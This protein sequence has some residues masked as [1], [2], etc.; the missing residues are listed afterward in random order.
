MDCQHVKLAYIFSPCIIF[1]RIR[2]HLGIRLSLL[3]YA[4]DIDDNLP[5]NFNWIQHICYY[6]FLYVHL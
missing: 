2:F 1:Q 5:P 3:D 4:N 6:K